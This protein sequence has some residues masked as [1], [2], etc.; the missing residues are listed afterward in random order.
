M[1]HDSALRTQLVT[2]L[3]WSD[4]HAGFEAAVK[5]IAPKVRGAVPN[6]WDYSAWQLVEHMRMAQDDI[7]AFCV[8]SSYEEKKWPDEYWPTSPTPPSDAA[9]DASLAAYRRDRNAM[10][11][12]AGNPDIDLFATVPNG[13]TQTYLREILLVADHTAYHVGQLISLRK[14]LGIWP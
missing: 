11:R 14:Q 9:W 4:A 5:G 8:S 13:T 6:G 10:Q 2:L 7:L 1:Q 3:D 12:L